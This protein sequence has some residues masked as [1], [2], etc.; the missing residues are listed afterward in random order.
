LTPKAKPETEEKRKTIMAIAQDGAILTEAEMGKLPKAVRDQFKTLVQQG[1]APKADGGEPVKEP[2][3]L[4]AIEDPAKVVEETPK[5]DEQAPKEEAH[6]EEPKGETVSRSEYDKQ[7][8]RYNTLQG[9]HNK[10]I[11]R[12]KGEIAEL[13]RANAL[14]Q[15]NFD[16]SER[17]R[18]ELES[19]LSDASKSPAERL[20]LS[21]EDEA[22]LGDSL[23]VV[24][25]VAKQ[26]ASKEIASLREENERRRKEDSDRLKAESD[27]RSVEGYKAA[28]TQA[29]PDWMEINQSQLFSEWL[30]AEDGNSGRTLRESLDAHDNAHDVLRV[31]KMMNQFK[32]E[33]AAASRTPNGAKAVEKIP[34]GEQLA[35]KSGAPAIASQPTAADQ[36]IHFIDE[37]ME[38]SQLF[39]KKKI[40]FEEFQRRNAEFDRAERE[41]R[42]RERK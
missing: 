26:I 38:N 42:V 33:K 40:S 29:V 24:E 7:V 31:S 6:R 32:A 1:E 23:P 15:K 25:R 18:A 10:E 39:T 16:L 37:P 41:G 22:A 21:V 3:K 2:E 28:L 5:P 20:G 19:K 12:L 30:D 11:P 9:M 34:L 17:L 27:V 14:L 4:V 8:A 35:P 13:G 36:K